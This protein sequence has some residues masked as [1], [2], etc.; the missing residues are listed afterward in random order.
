MMSSHPLNI[1]YPLSAS[2]V[3]IGTA[4]GIIGTVYVTLRYSI[5][6]LPV[7]DRLFFYV[8]LQPNIRLP[9]A[10]HMFASSRT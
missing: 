1:Y 2:L 3:F 8:R 7:Q 10:E 6:R 4:F 9:P 5:R